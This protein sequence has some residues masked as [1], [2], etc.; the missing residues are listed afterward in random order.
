[1]LF[2]W[3]LPA[4]CAVGANDSAMPSSS[5]D[6]AAQ[7]AQVDAASTAG[8]VS[9]S[10][11]SEGSTAGG[12]A[13]EPNA[14]VVTGPVIGLAR[15][16]LI[17]RF[18]TVNPNNIIFG[19]LGSRIGVAFTG[20][21]ITMMMSDSSTDYFDVVIDGNRQTQ[22]VIV[23]PNTVAQPYV[24]GQNLSLGQHTLWLTKRTEAMQNSASSLGIAHLT[25]MVLD[26]NAVFLTPPAKRARRIEFVGDSGW[27][28]YGSEALVGA[29]GTSNCSYSLNTQN[30]LKSVPEYTA[31]FLN[32]DHVNASVTGKGVYLSFYDP[33]NT[34]HTFPVLYEMVY[35]PSGPQYTFDASS[36]DAV[37][38]SV[39]GDDLWGNG[40]SGYFP[41][42]ASPSTSAPAS[43]S[44]PNGSDPNFF[45]NAMSQFLV[46]IN[47]HYPNTP[48][49]CVLSAAATSNDITTLGNGL[50][51]AIALAKTKGVANAVYYSYFTG[52]PTYHTY[53]DAA[54]ALQLYYGCDYHPSA[55]GAQWLS[56][57][58][59]GFIAAQKGW[60]APPAAPY[61]AL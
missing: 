37:V 50:Q 23:N 28:G 17:G 33:T 2:M 15:Y 56:Y 38:L 3:T 39:G 5:S 40:G 54:N 44:N 51:N 11:T 10:S 60:A 58:L 26:A 20:T 7:T 45:V 31:D 24:L 42:P 32:A 47:K 1:M 46:Q 49:I 13:A 43:A 16:T 30:A 14:V 57:R 59:A 22:P 36:V 12:I 52:D 21:S 34:Q 53:D 9:V 27:S 55:A 61:S 48:I 8:A 19:L 25:D 18:T 41:N 4:G 6:D 35:P 29:P